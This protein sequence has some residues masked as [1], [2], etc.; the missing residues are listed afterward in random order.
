MTKY[1]LFKVGALRTHTLEVMMEK[2]TKILLFLLGTIKY[3]KG[4]VFFRHL[5][6]GN[7]N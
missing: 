2:T 5:N 7:A 6:A 4:S 3:T 1:A